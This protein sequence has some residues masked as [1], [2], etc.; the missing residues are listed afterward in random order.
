MPDL[1]LSIMVYVALKR[2][3][4]FALI[5][6]LFL[7]YLV[8]LNS[9]V[10][11]FPYLLMSTLCFGIARYIGLNVFTGTARSVL[12]CVILSVGVP[13]VLF[14]LWLHWSDVYVILRSLP[15]TVISTVTT[16]FIGLLLFRAFGYLDTVT[17]VIEP[18]YIKERHRRF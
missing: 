7:V 11:F 13:K 9:S 15:P 5:Y 14:I 12:W 2:E 8:S 1:I 6:S 4:R 10:G 18:E 16:S 17:G 3:L